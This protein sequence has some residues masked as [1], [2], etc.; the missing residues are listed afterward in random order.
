MTPHFD[1]RHYYLLKKRVLQEADIKDIVP[2]DCKYLS[3]T[4]FNKVH[5]GISETTLKR[6]FGFAFA[7]FKPSSFTINALA[8]YCGYDSWHAFQKDVSV[9][10]SQQGNEVQCRQT[11]ERANDITWTTLQIL[12]NK[13][14]I[15]YERTISRDFMHDHFQAFFNEDAI[16]TALLAPSGYGKTIALCHWVEDLMKFTHFPNQRDVILFFSGSALINAYE[17]GHNLNNWLLALLGLDADN[18]LNDMFIEGSGFDGKFYLIIDGLDEVHY[19]GFHF[20]NIFEQLNDIIALHNTERRLKIVITMRSA[21]WC[22]N[23]HYI[24]SKQHWFKGFVMESNNCINVPLMDVNEILKLAK[25]LN[26]DVKDH[27]SER[28]VKTLGL[29]LLTQYYFKKTDTSHNLSEFDEANEFDVITS[30]VLNKVYKS[31]HSIDMITF[32]REFLG[33]IDQSNLAEGVSK[34]RIQHLIKGYPQAYDELV[35]IGYLENL[36]AS[37]DAQLNNYVRFSSS[38]WLDHSVAEKL[39]YDNGEMFNE[40]LVTSINTNMIEECRRITVL[41]WCIYKT[42]SAHRHIDFNILAGFETTLSRK[43]DLISF[44]SKLLKRLTDEQS[45]AFDNKFE[46]KISEYFVGLEYANVNYEQALRTILKFRL[47]TKEQILLKC[48][49]CV[50]AILELDVNKLE[51][52]MEDLK[53]YSP[54]DFSDFV[55]DPLVCIDT[56]YYHLKYGIVKREGFS[57]I[58]KFYF[59]PPAAAFGTR[60]NSFNEVLFMLA[61]HTVTI[62]K[63]ALKTLRFIR[64]LKRIYPSGSEAYQFLLEISNVEALLAAGRKEEARNIYE[65]LSV[66]FEERQIGFTALMKV[67]FKALKVRIKALEPDEPALMQQI[68]ALIKMCD[69]YS[70]KL[71]KVTTLAFV[72]TE[73]NNGPNTTGD[74]L[75]HFYFD[76]VRTARSAGCRTESFYEAKIH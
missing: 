47:T 64:T 6:V 33:F 39:Y 23:E 42:I 14:G 46:G 59:N 16:A 19:K 28:A 72:L 63:G 74:V 11:I 61:T 70:Y 49:L 32:V 51:K 58:T 5:K 13:C 50:I 31:K 17:T 27:V 20:A 36:D 66:R 24:L 9:N 15:P 8:E 57:E 4:I 60:K 43:S 35:N 21:T 30:Y 29:P 38:R 7:E 18:F 12:K 44:V 1:P 54:E 26:P 69:E 48:S 71:V 52:L 45:P 73:L 3:L 34:L 40:Q 62:C 55:I 76:M 67:C 22:N 56:V 68:R 75:E 25:N 65:Q 53:N 41:K 37:C 10:N 2:S